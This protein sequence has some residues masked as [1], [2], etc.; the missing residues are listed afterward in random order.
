MAVVERLSEEDIY[1]LAILT[2]PS[3]VDQAEFL[4]EDPEQDHGR[5][6][7]W[8]YQKPWWRDQSSFS[9][10]LSARS[11]GKS[12]SI[13]VRL[14]AFPFCYPGQEAVIT[15]PTLNHLSP[16]TD[17]IERRFREVRVA[18]EL[19]PKKANLGFTHRPFAV[20]FKN[21]SRLMGRIPQ[22]DGSGVKGMHPLVLEQDEAQDYPAA[23]FTELIETVKQG[24]KGFQWRVHGVTNGARDQFYKISRPESGW[25]VHHIT[26]IDRPTWS[27][28]ERKNKIDSYGSRNSP[29]Y[30]RNIFGE[31][32][33]AENPMLVARRLL[34]CIDMNESSEYNQDTYQRVLVRAEQL[35]DYGGPIADLIDVPIA[36]KKRWK[37][38]WI[39]A[40]IGFTIDPTEIVVFGEETPKGADESTLTLL[41]RVTLERIRH[42]DQSEAMAHLIMKYN[43]TAM[44]MDKTGNGLPLFQDMQD[45]FP[46]LASKIRGY[47][48]SQKLIVDFD[49][50]I[51]VDP[52]VEDEIEK[53]KIEKNVLEHSSDIIRDLV[54]GYRLWLP[55]D[56]DVINSYRGE[57]YQNARMKTTDLYGRR[58]FSNTNKSHILDATRMMAMAW[59][60]WRIEAI[61]NQKP[62]P[63]DVIIPQWA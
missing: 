44:G 32:S 59:S 50:T 34:K 43:P 41:L 14:F 48:F 19:L 56:D 6:R 55:H 35:E 52:D 58:K 39:G 37:T 16:V 9:V 36:H 60:Q 24:S 23:G 31:P 46:S 7:A 18:R 45:R 26:A 11:V 21:G 63:D 27:D 51:D 62:E 40:D 28:A 53:T 25:K 12:T 54:D 30:R 10:D 47:G 20:M 4:W 57:T 42:Q 15:A 38:F 33:A 22:L 29:D 17:L 1:L 5:F 2:D 13:V 8:D 49:E 3:G 61:L